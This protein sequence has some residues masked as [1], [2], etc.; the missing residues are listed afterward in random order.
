MFSD[1]VGTET[2]SAFV[3]VVVGADRPTSSRYVNGVDDSLKVRLIDFGQPVTKNPDVVDFRQTVK[4]GCVLVDQLA[5]RLERGLEE[6][7]QMFNA[8][9]DPPVGVRPVRLEIQAILGSTLPAMSENEGF[10][11]VSDKAMDMENPLRG[12]SIKLLKGGGVVER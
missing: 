10:G 6:G 3:E 12:H 8:V 4:E 9:A 1:P 5:R 11:G 2:L 7:V